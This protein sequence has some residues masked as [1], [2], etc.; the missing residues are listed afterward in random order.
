MTEVGVNQAPATL[1]A[2]ITN[3]ATTAVLSSSTNGWPGESNGPAFA[4]MRA[5]ITD[6]TN[7]EIVLVTANDG[8]GNV[9]IQR[10]VEPTNRGVQTA[11]GFA[12]GSTITPVATA[13]GHY[14]GT[15][16]S[17]PVWL[18]PVQW[19]YVNLP[20]AGFNI[21]PYSYDSLG[22]P[23]DTVTQDTPSDGSLTINGGTPTVGDRVAFADLAGGY[24][25]A[26]VYTVTALG[27]GST[28]PWVLTRATDNDTAA[29]LGT[30]WAVSV[31]GDPTFGGGLVGVALVPPVG[32]TVGTSYVDLNVAGP[33]G[34][35]QGI[36]FAGPDSVA[37][38]LFAVA[39]GANSRALG[40]SAQATGDYS[41]AIGFHAEASALRA[42]GI[43]ATASGQDA[44]A[45]GRSSV[46][47]APD[48]MGLNGGQATETGAT[49]IGDGCQATG[50]GAFAIG[51]GAQATG[52]NSAAFGQSANAFAANSFAAANYGNSSGVG[53]QSYG[54]GCEAWGVWYWATA[55]GYYATPGD[56][57]YA[58][59]MPYNQTTDAT[60]TALGVLSVINSGPP[61]TLAL[62]FPDFTHTILIEARVVARRTDVPGTVSVWECNNI[63]VD[64]DGVGAYR[65]V[66]SQTLTVV[67]QDAA[68]SGWDVAFSLVDS[69]TAFAITV[70]GEVGSTIQWTCTLKLYEVAG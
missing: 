69:D 15:S 51:S 6:G 5:T 29:T 54:Y 64:G 66:G 1:S 8:A 16:P 20:V 36:A 41:T 25:H 53:G 37:I 24:V 34:Y 18:A 68:A 12:A 27:D 63:V 32:F 21:D 61:D 59:W 52:D 65:L 33:G 13:A 67:Q 26:G 55:S 46:A 47:S 43:N 45:V 30:Y 58:F 56:S 57:Q 22:G 62:T 44:I 4:N 48:S 49:A 7:Y 19:C 10:A 17:E 3:I 31:Q 38:G 28:V 14:P 50:I 70:T 11:F 2:P 42:V 40:D 9:T 60:P 23:G 39:S 35:A